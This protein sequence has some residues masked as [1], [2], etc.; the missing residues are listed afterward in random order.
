MTT[1]K[2]T[3]YVSHYDRKEKPSLSLFVKK[4]FSILP[5]GICQP[6]VSSESLI[7]E[8]IYYDHNPD[9]LLSDIDLYP[10]KPYTDVV[11]Q[12]VVRE[13]SSLT[14][15][16]VY[17]KVNNLT[18][19]IEVFGNR[20]AYLDHHGNIQFTLPDVIDEVPLRYDYAYGGKDEFASS[21]YSYPYPEIL[22]NLSSMVSE[23][24]VNPFIYERNSLG[25]GYLIKKHPKALENFDLPNLEDSRNL[26]MPN[27]LEVLEPSNWTK[28]PLPRATDWVDPSWF[29]RMM[30]FGLFTYPVNL[31]KNIEEIKRNWSDK[32]IVERNSSNGQSFNFR[33]GNGASLGL[34]LPHLQ[35]NETIEI[36]NHEYMGSRYSCRLPNM[37]PKLFIDDRKGGLK[38]VHTV[39]Q[40]AVIDLERNIL[41]MVW[42]GSSQAIRPYLEEELS[43]MPYNVLWK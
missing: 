28:M 29:P 34:Q 21:N 24:D 9:Q 19:S 7:E 15:K 38:S 22:K 20:K 11:I 14:R 17:F 36:I 42:C 3:L 5:N 32:S 39:L 2:N 6:L 25:K 27:S 23:D 41:N 12:G 33:A 16:T 1:A 4:T 26:L 35:G 10:L 8:P 37:I 43:S 13:R 30:Y 31:E 18:S 40:S